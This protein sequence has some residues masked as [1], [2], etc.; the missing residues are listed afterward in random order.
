MATKIPEAM[1]RMYKNIFICKNCKSR[2]RADPRRIMSSK[3]RC[4]KCGYDQ[5]R[6]KVKEKKVA[7]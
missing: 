6:A 4:R 5:L 2:V 7:K 3:V 1:N